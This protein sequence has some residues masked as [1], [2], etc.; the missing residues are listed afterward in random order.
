[1]QMSNATTDEDLDEIREEVFIHL[2]NIGSLQLLT[3]SRSW[4]WKKFFVKIFLLVQPT[5]KSKHFLTVAR[6]VFWFKPRQGSREAY[7][8][9]KALAGSAVRSHK[10]NFLFL[11]MCG[12]IF[13]ELLD[14]RNQYSAC[15]RSVYTTCTQWLHHPIL[16]ILVPP[17]IQHLVIFQVTCRT[18]NRKTTL[19]GLSTSYFW[20]RFGC[21]KFFCRSLEVLDIAF[22]LLWN[23]ITNITTCIWKFAAQTFS[24]SW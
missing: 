5:M 12:S 15:N 13:S 2:A 3:V 7:H 8:G 22:L 1:M 16:Y 6:V 20:Y 9:P 14:L 17:D 4:K 18:R 11:V 21:S 10:V 23:F 24:D 19:H